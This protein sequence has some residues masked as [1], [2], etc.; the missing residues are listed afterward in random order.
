MPGHVDHAVG[1]RAAS[2]PSCI[3]TRPEGVG[4][5]APRDF[6]LA[7]VV[8]GDLLERRVVRVRVVGAVGRPL[9]VRRAL[10][11]AQMN[12]RGGKTQGENETRHGPRQTCFHSVHPSYERPH[13][14]AF[15]RRC[16]DCYGSRRPCGRGMRRP[17]RW[18]AGC[19][20][21]GRAHQGCQRSRS[22]KTA[23]IP[24]DQSGA[25]GMAHETDRHGR[26]RR[27]GQ[28]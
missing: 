16:H 5:E 3:G 27:Q 23:L 10:L 11:A 25:D 22:S 15:S 9:A 14:R 12:R 6:E 28:D 8:L 24:G 7:E 2:T 17:A 21:D 18:G 1:F 19:G 13:H 26:Q 20:C 4:F